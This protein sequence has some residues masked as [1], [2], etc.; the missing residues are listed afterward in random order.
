MNQSGSSHYDEL[1]IRVD[2]DVSEITRAYRRAAQ[3]SHP[4]KPGGSTEKFQKVKLAYE[5]LSDQSRRTRYDRTGESGHLDALGQARLRVLALLF[6]AIDN[7]NEERTDIIDAIR[8]HVRD[9][10]N[11]DREA[12]RE[13][14][15]KIEK[16][17][18]ALRR[19]HSKEGRPNL[20]AQAIE[21]DIAERERRLEVGME[22]LQSHKE[23]YKLLDDYVYTLDLALPTKGGA[24]EDAGFRI[25]F[26]NSK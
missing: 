11:H 20:L 26:E 21:R 14:R 19:L 1:G 15:R 5:V 23:V 7:L 4:D 12:I 18:R 17:K 10:E 24:I 6:S 16:R 8:S 3:K 22:Q 25:L 13:L 2:A 9:E